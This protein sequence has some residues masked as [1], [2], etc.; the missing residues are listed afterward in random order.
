MEAEGQHREEGHVMVEAEIVLPKLGLCPPMPNK[1][2]EPEFWVK[3]KKI[4]F[5]VLPGKGG[6]G[7]LMLYFILF[8][9]IFAFLPFREPL[10]RHMDVPRLGV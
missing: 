2:L 4:A 10:P 7:R 8:Y 6:H 1:N 5:I 3:Q 9:F